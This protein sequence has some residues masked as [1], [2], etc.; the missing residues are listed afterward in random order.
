MVGQP[1]AD[2]GNLR[3]LTN[4]SADDWY[5]SWS[6]DG[7]S[8][9]FVSRR[10][11]NAEIYVMDADGGNLRRLT[12]HSADDWYPSWSAD[13][14]SIAFYSYRDGNAEIYVMDADGSNLRRL[15]NH[16]ADD[17]S[18]SWSADGR[19]IAFTSERDGNREIYV[20]DADG[21]NLTPADQPQCQR[22]LSLLVSGWSVYRLLLLPR[23][24]RGDLRDGPSGVRHPG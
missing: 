16:S 7:R 19:S 21:G 10:D 6:A 20:M 8:I 9:A 12:N 1:A 11:G 13:G 3:R 17:Y 2:G 24:Q 15:T 4:H 5:P 23:W 22:L 14:R 18:P